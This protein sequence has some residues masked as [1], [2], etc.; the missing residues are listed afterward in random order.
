MLTIMKP[1]TGALRRRASADHGDRISTRKRVAALQ[2]VLDVQRLVH[3]WVRPHHGLAKNTTPAMAI[4]YCD[5]PVT[6]REL[7][8]QRGFA[9]L[10]H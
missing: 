6:M 1:K 9:S 5:Y 3:N 2:R 10:I 7:L 8:T 4:G